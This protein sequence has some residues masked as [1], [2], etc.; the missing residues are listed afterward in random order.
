MIYLKTSGTVEF[1]R[2]KHVKSFLSLYYKQNVVE[3]V[4]ISVRTFISSFF[5]EI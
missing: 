1:S 2:R 5:L 4:C 3:I